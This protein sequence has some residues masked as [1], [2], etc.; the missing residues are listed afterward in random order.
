MAGIGGMGEPGCDRVPAL[1]A[2]SGA[3]QPHGSTVWIRAPAN[4]VVVNT[5]YLLRMVINSYEKEAQLYIL[6]LIKAS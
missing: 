2:T 5:G 3:P 1:T 4:R 6:S